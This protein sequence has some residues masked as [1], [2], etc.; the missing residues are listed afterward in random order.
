MLQLGSTSVLYMEG[1]PRKSVVADSAEVVLTY[2]KR[3]TDAE[4]WESVPKNAQEVTKNWL[5][6]LANV[7]F[8]DV[9]P[10]T[11]IAGVNDGLQMNVFAPVSA[12][13]KLLRSNGLDGIFVRQ[14]IESDKIVQPIGRPDAGRRSTECLHWSSAISL[15]ESLRRGSFRNRF[16][17][18]VKACDFKEIIVLWQA[19]KR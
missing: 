17:I 14:F 18:R 4:A 9:R 19:Q 5:K 2:A 11:R 12:I 6:L 16:G 15:R 8:L 7:E 10:P 1:T 13:T 3:R